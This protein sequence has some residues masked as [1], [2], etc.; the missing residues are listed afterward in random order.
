VLRVFADDRVI[1][2]H[3]RR[4]QLVAFP[5]DVLHEVTEVIG[6]TRDAIVDWFYGA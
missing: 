3:P 5:A 4:G 2:V 6:G 1:D